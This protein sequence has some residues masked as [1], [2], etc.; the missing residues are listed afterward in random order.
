M[1]KFLVIFAVIFISK[2]IILADQGRAGA[3]FLKIFPGVYGPSLA[4]AGST[5]GNSAEVV[6]WNPAGLNNLKERSV[7]LSH[8]DYFVD[9]KYENFAVALP[10][11]YGVFAIHGIGLLSGDIRETTVEEPDGTGDYYSKN[12]FALGLSYGMQ[13]TNKFYMGVT[14]RSIYMSIAHLGAYGV[15]LD[16]GAKYISGLPGNLIFAFTIKNF[17][18]DI[19]Y[20]GS[21]LEEYTTKNENE[22]EEEDVK[23][24]YVAE[25]FAL[26][27][28]FSYA[29]SGEI[30]ITESQ[31]I[32]IAFENWQVIDTKEVYRMG[33][34]WN[35][36]NLFYLS[37][38]HANLKRLFHP[39]I[40]AEDVNGNMQSWCFGGGLNLGKVFRKKFWVK[41]AWEAHEY[42]NG[43]NRIGI[44]I[45]F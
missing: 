19:G 3:Q 27:L 5:L 29:V 38:G 31:K 18:P 26:P 15:S 35:V 23:I 9:I 11:S 43:I 12:D 44:D 42:F 16:A 4:G 7:F 34:T 10:T 37:A 41:Y 21:D 1:K 28:S 30:P 14:A 32:G 24:E 17:G 36:D 45:S 22:F 25:K 33:L 8:T 40:D 13:M 39:D 20:S 2:N 6:F